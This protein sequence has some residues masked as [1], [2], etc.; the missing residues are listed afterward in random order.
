MS[1]LKIVPK[2]RD[3][4]NEKAINIVMH[5]VLKLIKHII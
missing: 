1:K 4:L 2:K 5:R 3:L